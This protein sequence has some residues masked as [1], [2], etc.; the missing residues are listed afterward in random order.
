MTVF[1]RRRKEMQ[2]VPMCIINMFPLSILSKMIHRSVINITISVWINDR[3]FA[4]RAS[5]SRNRAET[6]HRWISSPSFQV[7][8]HSS[9]WDLT[10]AQY[11]GSDKLLAIQWGG[12]LAMTKNHFQEA[13]GQWGP[14]FG[15]CR[16]IPQWDPNPRVP[17]KSLFQ[18]PCY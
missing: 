16:G 14:W 2:C 17:E 1:Q 3:K 6:Y 11:L 9:C 8:R 4:Q 5:T 10:F 13:F 12:C 18:T 15:G 7:L